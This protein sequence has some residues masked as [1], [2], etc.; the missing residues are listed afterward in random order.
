MNVSLVLFYGVVNDGLKNRE[1]TEVLSP[2]VCTELS[3]CTRSTMNSGRRTMKNELNRRRSRTLEYKLRLRRSETKR[4]GERSRPVESSHNQGGT[5]VVL[6][7]RHTVKE[8]L[9]EVGITR[10]KMSSGSDEPRL[11]R[12]R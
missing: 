6:R 11:G 8:P 7:V 12:L 10:M 4:G 1:R 5:V 3:T 9:E 2:F